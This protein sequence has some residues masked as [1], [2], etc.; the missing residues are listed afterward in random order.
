MYKPYAK[1]V[2]ELLMAVQCVTSVGVLQSPEAGMIQDMAG[3]GPLGLTPAINLS[4]EGSTSLHYLKG[5][6]I[7]S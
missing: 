5:I 2:Y 4:M 6:W 1:S 7:T 3:V